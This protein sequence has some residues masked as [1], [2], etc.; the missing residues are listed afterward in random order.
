MDWL[1]VASGPMG[2]LALAVPLAAVLLRR[3]DSRYAEE[4]AAARAEITA[5]KIEIAAARKSL[6]DEASAR[7]ADSK[8]NARA[9]LGIYERVHETL[10]GLE[11]LVKADRSKSE[12]PQSS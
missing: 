1:T 11:A 2:A 12:P 9:M 3:L 8:E 10:D 7:L 4:L 6:E 5:L